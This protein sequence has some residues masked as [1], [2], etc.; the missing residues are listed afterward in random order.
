VRSLRRGSLLCS[1]EVFVSQQRVGC[2]RS[3]RPVVDSLQSRQQQA[4]GVVQLE[5]L[6]LLGQQEGCLRLL[7]SML[8]QLTL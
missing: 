5:W 6:W 2:N 4:C 3:P 8:A 1:K 7:V